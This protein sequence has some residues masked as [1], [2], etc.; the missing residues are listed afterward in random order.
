[1]KSAKKITKKIA[2]DRSKLLGFRLEEGTGSAGGA[3]LGGKVGGKIGAKIGRKPR[4][5]S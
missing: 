4:R 2:I 3:K 1:M 5:T